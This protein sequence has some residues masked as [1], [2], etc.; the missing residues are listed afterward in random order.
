MSSFMSIAVLWL[1]TPFLFKRELQNQLK[2]KLWWSLWTSG[3]GWK[4]C[5]LM[6]LSCA[7]DGEGRTSNVVDANREFCFKWKKVYFFS[8]AAGWISSPNYLTRH[9]VAR[10]ME[11]RASPEILQ[12]QKF[13]KLFKVRYFE[14]GEIIE[15]AFP[16]LVDTNLDMIESQATEGKHL[17]INRVMS[18][19][20][21]TTAFS[22]ER[23]IWN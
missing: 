7:V 5:H 10:H 2:Q 13:W 1:V 15:S 9:V 22:F 6:F 16:H 4:N 17:Q 11:L 23:R 3:E 19:S 18:S 8:G 12:P 20:E 14:F 21:N